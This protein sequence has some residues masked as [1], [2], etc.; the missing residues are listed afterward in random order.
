MM[1]VLDL[2]DVALR[3]WYRDDSLHS[4]G[5]AWFDGNG[6]HF[7]TT[8]SQTSRRTP[9][10]V[11]TRF[12]SQLNTQALTPAV[13]P[14]RHA[15][16]LVHGHLESLHQSVGAPEKVLI[17]APGNMTREQ[18]SMLLGIVQALPFNIGGLVHRTSVLGAAS[19][20]DQGLHVE[21]QLHQLVVTPFQT[22][23]GHTEAGESQ[24]LPGRGLLAL[25]DQLATAI[26]G[27]FVA[28]TRFDP[29]RSAD[30]EQILYDSL[31][32]ILQT[33][34]QRGETA[35][36]I[37]GYRARI[38]LG[39]LT[40][41]GQRLADQLAP[42]LDQDLAVLLE[43]PLSLLPGLALAN[44]VRSINSDALHGLIN[45]QLGQLEQSPDALVLKRQV[46][47]PASTRDALSADSAPTSADGLADTPAYTPAGILDEKVNDPA[48]QI[49]E[50]ALRPTHLLQGNR[51][52]AISS[53]APLA[54]G[55]ELRFDGD[56][57]ALTGT[58]PPDFLVNGAVATPGCILR[59][60]DELSDSLGFQARLIIVED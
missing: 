58:V 15:A 43:Y 57:L 56:T 25:Q 16:D 36:E 5:Y 37:D 51:A 1:G 23:D 27:L 42:L 30:A 48:L 49:A 54:G 29:L 50:P 21:L 7:G 18:L 53:N 60:G 8:A 52:T 28:Q 24:T 44:E 26:S 9:R 39:D 4:P 17:A 47:R 12:W 40:G 46:P 13:G 10:A 31:G 55:I 33:I 2:N 11:N 45:E 32:S 19:G 41:I 59:A 35:L 6:Y 14:A 20:L 22:V 34:G 3:L 38:S